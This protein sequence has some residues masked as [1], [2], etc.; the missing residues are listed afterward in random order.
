[1]RALGPASH[2]SDGR[3][4]RHAR[5]ARHDS[6]DPLPAPD[7]AGGARPVDRQA[8]RGQARC[9]Q[10]GSKQIVKLHDLRPAT[11]AR[12]TRTRVGRG[13]AGRARPPAAAPRASAHA[14]VRAFP[15]GSRAAR[16][17]SI[18]ACPSCTASRTSSAS[19]TRWSTWA[20]SRPMP[21]P[22]AWAPPSRPTVNAKSLAQAGLIRGDDKPL[23]V[24][25]QGE[26]GARLLR[27]RG[28]LQRQRQVEDR[29][30]RW[31]RA[32]AGAGEDRG[33]RGHG[34]QR[35]RR[36]AGPARRPRPRDGLGSSHPTAD[37]AAPGS[38]IQRS[39]RPIGS[40]RH[41]NQMVKIG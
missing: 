19:S 31:L 23:K 24:L 13:R 11:G 35:R 26:V 39:P 20:K 28:R 4:R 9:A 38:R 14:R 5:A 36:L 21:R 12:K 15:P 3:R 37:S 2:R 22:V 7:R 32:A 34:A 10:E 27:R 40:S 33:R 6:G 17:R 41:G 30:R 25:G 29:G 1:M 16:R 18:S 8:G